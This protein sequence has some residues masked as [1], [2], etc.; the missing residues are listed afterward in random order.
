MDTTTTDLM[1]KMTTKQLVGRGLIHDT[2]IVHISRRAAQ[3]FITLYKMMCD[4]ELKDDLFLEL[5][6]KCT[7][8]VANCEYL[9]P[10]EDKLG[11]RKVYYI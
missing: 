8:I 9:K 11:I 7:Q 6:S 3:I 1:N 5:S 2:G 10:Q 4:L